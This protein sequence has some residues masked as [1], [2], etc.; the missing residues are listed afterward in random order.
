MK[1]NIQEIYGFA[2]CFVTIVC[3]VFATGVGLYDLL[4]I[5][6]PEFTLS[7]HKY[8]KFQ[9][10]DS[11]WGDKFKNG[12][13][14]LTDEEL[15][16]KRLAAYD[17]ALNNEQRNAAQSLV[18]VIIILVIDAGVFLLHWRLARRSRESTIAI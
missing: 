18:K 16:K 4:E 13:G 5:A 7:A 10:N 2:V 17:I 15:T 12:E 6:K 14:K 11:F 1:K 3:A 9:T 8:Q